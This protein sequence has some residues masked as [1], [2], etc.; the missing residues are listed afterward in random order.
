MTETQKTRKLRAGRY[1]VCLDTNKTSDETYMNWIT[2]RLT[3]L[4][5]D[6]Y[7]VERKS[8]ASGNGQTWEPCGE[9]D[10]GCLFLMRLTGFGP[11]GRP[12]YRHATDTMTVAC[13]TL[14]AR[15]FGLR[16]ASGTNVLFP[17]SR[18]FRPTGRKTAAPS[19]LRNSRDKNR[20]MAREKANAIDIAAA[21][22]QRS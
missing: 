4:S 17:N 20:N 9:I 11:N 18:V 12:A 19:L 13:G 15:Y 14:L 5:R 2:F 8:N 7:A 21:M 16:Y 3:R 22:A 1:T 10:K 6:R